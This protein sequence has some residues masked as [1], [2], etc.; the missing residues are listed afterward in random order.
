M[1]AMSN[2]RSSLTA[3]KR[4]WAKHLS[5]VWSHL[6]YY[7]YEPNKPSRAA[8]LKLPQAEQ[9][10][11]IEADEPDFAVRLYGDGYL[12]SSYQ[13]NS[14]TLDD[15]LNAPKDYGIGGMIEAQMAG[16]STE[17]VDEIE[18]GATLNDDEI[19][20]LQYAIAEDDYHGWDI[21]SGCYIKLRFGAVFA[22]YEGEDIGQ[23]GA[24]FELEHVFPDRRKAMAYLS[25]KPFIV[26]EH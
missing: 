21:H 20:A 12:G 23:G 5:N 11:W 26:I 13:M 8:F 17:R 24:S 15:H 6:Q 16:I 9:E 22:V 4:R 25:S 2:R 18:A 7:R 14:F 19:E 3:L 1:S 10:V